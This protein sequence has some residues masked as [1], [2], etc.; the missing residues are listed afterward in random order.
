MLGTMSCNARVLRQMEKVGFTLEARRRGLW[1]RQRERY[2]EMVY[3][4][5]RDEWPGRAARSSG[6][7]FS[8]AG[9]G[10]DRLSRCVYRLDLT[11]VPLSNQVGEGEKRVSARRVGAGSCGW[12]E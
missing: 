12:A 11:L 9:P 2:D 3:G 8:L 4:M 7:G 5:L 6:W 10:R 1:Q